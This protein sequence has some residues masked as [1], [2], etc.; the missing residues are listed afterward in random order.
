M[1]HRKQ[2]ISF[3]LFIDL[4]RNEL[5]S[6]SVK[7]RKFDIKKIFFCLNKVQLKNKKLKN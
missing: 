2:F 7:V 6:K 5:P 4:R 1:S 3:F